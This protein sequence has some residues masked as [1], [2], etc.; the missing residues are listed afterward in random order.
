M[1]KVKPIYKA[2]GIIKIESY[3]PSGNNTT[4][5]R[6]KN[7]LVSLTCKAMFG[8]LELKSEIE[9]VAESIAQKLQTWSQES[10][11]K[12][13]A[14]DL[15]IDVLK[16]ECNGKDE[17]GRKQ[18]FQGHEIGEFLKKIGFGQETVVYVTQ[19]KWS[20]DLNALRYMFPKTYTKVIFL[21]CYL[22]NWISFTT[23][24]NG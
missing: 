10:S 18:C 15:R 9:E 21:L 3:F 7:N 1:K 4:M 16:K 6:N 8:T 19:T 20:P 24:V 14:V 2:K 12:F 5:G 17:K 22:N 13:I 23:M 11:G